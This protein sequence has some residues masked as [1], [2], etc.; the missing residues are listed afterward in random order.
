MIPLF[1]SGKFS[2]RSHKTM[3]NQSDL[4]DWQRAAADILTRCPNHLLGAAPGCGKTITTLTAIA[5]VNT[6]KPTRI[7][8]VGPEIILE[9][10]WSVEAANWAHTRHLTFDMAHRYSGADR[11][12]LWFQGTGDIVTCTMDTLPRFLEAVHRRELMPIGRIIADESHLFKNSTSVRSRALQA[13][14]EVVPTWLLSGTVTPNGT[15]DSW[16]PGTIASGRGA[17][18]DKN[19]FQWRNKYFEQKG[20]YSWRPKSKAIEDKIR[21]ELKQHAVAIRLDQSGAGIPEPFFATYRFK[22]DDAHRQRIADFEESMSVQLPNGDWRFAESE[23]SCLAILRQLTSG[24]IYDE[25][26]D[27]TML[28]TARMDAAEEVVDG[29]EGP[30]L[31]PIFYKVE[32]NALKNRFKGS[33]LFV[34]STPPAERA[35]LINDF[36]ADRVPVMICAPSAMATGVNLQLGSAKTIIWHSNG[37]DAAARNQLN[38]RLIRS[39]QKN[40]VSVVTLV[41]D[42]GLDQPILDSFSKK[43]SGEAALMDLLDIRQRLKKVRP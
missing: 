40:H 22:W 3:L 28:S 21:E 19:F 10:V 14:S 32:A 1:P 13:L 35:Q 37:W 36:N 38:A 23:G 12:R 2:E 6:Q 42:A 30:V 7:L 34:G 31:I 8:L 41:A 25:M 26:G 5:A 16:V 29:V 9:T 43:Q 24:L 11:E 33:R 18:W 39:G 15:I 27:G 20:Q 4:R 17:F